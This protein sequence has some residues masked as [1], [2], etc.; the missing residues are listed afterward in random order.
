MDIS[1]KVSRL[2]KHILLDSAAI[3]M[4]VTMSSCDYESGSDSEDK[5]DYVI[6]VANIED[7]FAI[8]WPQS[9]ETV[10]SDRISIKGVGLEENYTH[11]EVRV[12]TDKWYDQPTTINE[13]SHN[14]SWRASPVY[15]KGQGQY[16]NHT[17]EMKVFYDDGTTDFSK[18]SDIIRQ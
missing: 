2:W 12:K 3:A 11:I 13:H 1:S 9:G 15:L 14:N 8:V 5:S 10:T 7:D 17:I 18:V 6:P 16:N 4:A